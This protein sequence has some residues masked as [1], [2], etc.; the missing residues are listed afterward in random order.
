MDLK[1]HFEETVEAE[2]LRRSI[3]FEYTS[4]NAKT[5]VPRTL[6]AG[7]YYFCTGEGKGAGFNKKSLGSA[8]QVKYQ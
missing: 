1:D 2:K 5:E 4:S 6:Q 8:R 3:R 7:T